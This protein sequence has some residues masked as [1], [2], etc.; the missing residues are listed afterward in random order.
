LATK[1]SWLWVLALVTGT[2]AWGEPQP[3]RSKL[4]LPDPPAPTYKELDVRKATPPP[5]P[6]QAAPQGAPN[7]VLILLDDFG[8]GQAGTFGGPI[9][10]PT[11]DRLASRGLRY[12]HF[13]VTALCS[14]TRMA[15]LTG[16]NHHTCNAGAVMDVATA[17]PGNTGVRPRSVAPLAEIL[18]LNGYNTAAFGKY[19][20]TPP[21]EASVAGPFERWPTRSGFEKFYGFIG[22]ETNQW[23]PLIYD[24]TTKVEIPHDP[25]YFFTTDM[26]NRAVDW[27]KSQQALTPDRPFF[28]YY[29][30][31]ATHAPHHVP[32]SWIEKY[33]GRFDQGWD[34]LREDTLARQKKLGVVPADTRLAP[35]PEGIKD[36][37]DL[38]PAQRQLFARQMEV[39]AGFGE[40][41]DREIGRL[42]QSLEQVGALDNTLLIYIVGDN[43]ASP[44]G[45]MNGLFNEMTYFNAVP[46]TVEQQ[47][48]HVDD[49]GGPKAY[50]HYAAGWAIAGNTPFTWGKQVASHLGG[51][52]NPMVVHW[53][54]KIRGNGQLR[55]QFGHVTDIAPTVLEAAGLP[56]PKEVN[57][58]AQIP[59]E[60]QSLVHTFDDP[61]SPS[62]HRVQY[63]EITGNRAIYKDG[64]MASTV[65]RAPWENR[66]RRPLDQDQWELYNLNEDFSQSRDLAGQMPDKLKEMQ[67]LFMAEAEKHHVLPIDDRS[68]ERMNP[69]LAGRPDLMGGR[70][71]LMVYP[72]MSLSEN[73]FLN[74]KNHSWK[75]T[76]DLTDSQTADGVVIC[77]G[78]RFGGWS[79]H[80]RQGRP[81]FTY[82]WV[83][84]ERFTIA[85]PEAV[86]SGDCKLQLEFRSAGGPAGSG[87]TASLLINGRKVAEGPVEHTNRFTF[88]PDETMDVGVDDAT[89]VAEDYAASRFSGTLHQV[90]VELLD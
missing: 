52:R 60:G 46:E 15:L 76:A 85:S 48:Q 11:L 25:N 33:K 28:M 78:G 58:I 53:P 34:Q 86:P 22:G 81:V 49:L 84:L 38:T 7:V 59:M 89:P 57:G 62:R 88:S 36:W 51:T 35:K 5:R 3:D 6:A 41:T 66:P 8:F 31:G 21:W 1:H 65:H 42:V 39:F 12:N 90:L 68:L 44:E 18:R 29:A 14:P 9:A 64:W 23:A 87:G 69:E 40:H 77:Q 56:Q 13:H 47:L 73:T 30:P 20:E 54:K 75:M 45:G 72:G 83:G 82:N 16:R 74:I 17:F 55:T 4:P 10:T 32:R 63:F 67:S 27:V 70:K 37:K 61:A 43:G 71:K 26:T 80:L 50:S 19:H 79:L 24:G 2:G